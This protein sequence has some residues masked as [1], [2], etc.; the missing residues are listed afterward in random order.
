MFPLDNSILNRKPKMLSDQ[1]VINDFLKARLDYRKK[2]Y[3]A[4]K[5]QEESRRITNNMKKRCFATH[6]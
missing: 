1:R 2:L 6:E 3:T 5:N 4:L